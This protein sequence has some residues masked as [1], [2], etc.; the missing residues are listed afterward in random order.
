M[1]LKMTTCGL[2]VQLKTHSNKNDQST[3][4]TRRRQKIT[5]TKEAGNRRVHTLWPH[6]HK[7]HHDYKSGLVAAH[8][9]TEVL[10]KNS[11]KAS[12]TLLMFCFLGLKIQ[13][14]IDKC[15]DHLKF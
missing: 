12:R 7:L 9:D 13:K 8:R 11:R 5:W 3:S 15:M 14:A 2:F 10:G 1:Q 6:L 4:T